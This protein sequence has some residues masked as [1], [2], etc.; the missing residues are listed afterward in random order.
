MIPGGI[1][2]PWLKDQEIDHWLEAAAVELDPQK[3]AELYKKV[4][5]KLLDLAVIN[6]IYDFPYTVATSK[7]VQGIEFDSLGYPLFFDVHFTK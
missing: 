5:Q 3:R 6:P 7:K 2:I 4:Q 1:N